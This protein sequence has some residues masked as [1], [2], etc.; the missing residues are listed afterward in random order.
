MLTLGQYTDH[1]RCPHLIATLQRVVD[2]MAM[3]MWMPGPFSGTCPILVRGT[4][5]PR[6]GAAAAP[7]PQVDEYP[8]HCGGVVQVI[9]PVTIYEPV[10]APGC[11]HLGDLYMEDNRVKRERALKERAPT[12]KGI[13][14]LRAR[15]TRHEAVVVP[16]LRVPPPLWRA[17]PKDW[18]PGA[19]LAYHAQVVN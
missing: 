9:I 5:G 15:L 4:G 7:A 19:V 16:L 17:T 3:P 10:K 13:P 8:T 6:A 1:P 12:R 14:G 2:D 18:F 11:H